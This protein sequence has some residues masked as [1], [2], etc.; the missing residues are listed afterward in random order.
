[1]FGILIRAIVSGI[2][3]EKGLNILNGVNRYYKLKAEKIE[4]EEAR[5][6]K[7]YAER[8]ISID[9][10]DSVW[11]EPDSPKEIDARE[12]YLE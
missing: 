2:L 9:V 10:A 1:M 6:K 5:K 7:E 8:E 3:L 12:L 11:T 4:N